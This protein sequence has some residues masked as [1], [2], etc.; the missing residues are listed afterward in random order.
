[1][2]GICSKCDKESS[3]LAMGR[4]PECNASFLRKRNITKKFYKCPICGEIRYRQFHY[5]CYYLCKTDGEIDKCH[6]CDKYR[7]VEIIFKE[8]MCRPCKNKAASIISAK[9][10]SDRIKEEEEKNIEREKNRYKVLN[11]LEELDKCFVSDKCDI[12]K[13]HHEILKDDP[14]RLSTDFIKKLIRDED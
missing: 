6:K 4:C 11:D 2:I 13:K 14:E 1:M 10:T 8:S 9:R 5:I 3:H 12:L 7:H